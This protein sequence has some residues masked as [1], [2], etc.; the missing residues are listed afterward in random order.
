MFDVEHQVR[1][2]TVPLA[3]ANL[4]ASRRYGL[5]RFEGDGRIAAA[6]DAGRDENDR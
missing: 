5:V 1:V 2:L 6:S 4:A 3:D